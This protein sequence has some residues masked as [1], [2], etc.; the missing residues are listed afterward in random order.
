MLRRAL[1][2]L[3]LCAFVVSVGCEGDKP[4]NPDKLEYGKDGPPKRDGAPKTK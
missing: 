4:T 2:A 3:C 1:L